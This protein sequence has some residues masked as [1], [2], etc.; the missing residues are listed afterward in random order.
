MIFPAE[1]LE[2]IIINSH[3]ITIANIVK[4]HISDVCYQKVIKENGCVSCKKNN[5]FYHC[6]RHGKFFEY[7]KL[8]RN[9]WQKN[10][11]KRDMS[12]FCKV[13]GLPYGKQHIKS[14]LWYNIKYYFQKL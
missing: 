8:K 7:Y 2:M 9:T 10:F 1:I 5:V 3:S 14:E 12:N 13:L 11:T 4:K 6:N